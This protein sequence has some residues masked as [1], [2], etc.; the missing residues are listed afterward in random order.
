MA[1][2]RS[3]PSRKRRS[4]GYV[5]L[6]NRETGE[7]LFPIEERPVPP[8]DLRG[9]QAWPTQPLPLKPPPFS[10]QAFT[11][12]D[13]T[14]ISPESH[15]AVL[16]RLRM[17]RT[18]RAVHSAQHA[19]HRH[20]SW[21]RRRRRVG[22]RR[23]RRVVRLALRERQ[24]DAVDPHDGR[25]RPRQADVGRRGGPAHLPDQ[26]HGVSWRR[27]EGRPNEERAGR[28]STSASA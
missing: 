10:R 1:A 28:W 2:S 4:P 21:I 14:D 11:E 26:L 6:F 8:S 7:P 3:T 27:A 19:G 16:E 25:D 17:T 23:V 5:F 20:L 9:E 13:V 18:G 24:R 15:A 22:R 12:A